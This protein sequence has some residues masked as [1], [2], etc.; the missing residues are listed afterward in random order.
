MAPPLA[1]RS[2]ADAV[3]PAAKEDISGTIVA[4]ASVM[5]SLSTL[6]VGLRFYVRGKMLRAIA[7]EDWCILAA[8]VGTFS[9][10][11]RSPARSRGEPLASML[12]LATQVFTAATSI[13]AIKGASHGLHH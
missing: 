10:R 1:P 6:V 7:S 4:C 3:T 2:A 8:W 5:L 11:G 13:G 9:S 12:T